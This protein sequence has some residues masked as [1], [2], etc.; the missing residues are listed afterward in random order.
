MG[1]AILMILAIVTYT[2]FGIFVSKASGHISSGL[3]A[4]LFN[5]LG[6]VLPLVAIY[7]VASL[8]KAENVATTSSG[9]IYSILA[10][11]AIAAFSVLLIKLFQRDG[12]SFVMPMIYGG[13]IVLASIVGW[14][15]LKE[16]FSVTQLIGVIVIVAG[17][18]IVTY[19]K[20][21]S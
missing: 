10:G 5:G 4:L 8:R 14:L 1:Y 21:Y 18:G 7:S 2:L 20:I 12:V 13:S 6:A 17:V 11:V 3:S 9:I 19:S 16:T 15:V